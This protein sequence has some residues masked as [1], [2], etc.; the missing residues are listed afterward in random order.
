MFKVY[1][2][3]RSRQEKDLLVK[4]SSLTSTISN[5][6][7]S[8]CTSFSF[9]PQQINNNNIMIEHQNSCDTSDATTP[10]KIRNNNDTSTEST[11]VILKKSSGAEITWT[12]PLRGFTSSL[13]SLSSSASSLRYRAGTTPHT[14]DHTHSLDDI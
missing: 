6:F 13:F 11:P 12:S 5:Q 14:P 7:S 1:D 9:L 4:K 2:K 3:L 10:D 8:T